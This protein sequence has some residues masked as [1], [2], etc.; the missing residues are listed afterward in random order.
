MVSGPA[1][2]EKVATQYTGIRAIP[3]YSGRAMKFPRCIRLDTS[4]VYVYRRA[5]EPGEWAV[6]GGFAFAGADPK[7]LDA[8]ER[9][10]FQSGWLGTESFGHSSLVEVAEIEEA[11]FFQVVE[12]LARHFV[13]AYGA[14]DITAALPA[15][16]QEV[17]DAA[18]LCTHK[19]HSL[20][21]LEREMTDA[22]VVERFRVITPARAQDHARIWESLPDLDNAR[23]TE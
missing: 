9:L 13:A 6:P 22:G 16:R 18:G 10:A 1:D 12:R 19:I 17:D 7:A 8:K 3:D 5:A 14:P 4:D 2:E 21:A 15:A 11:E 23:D 20:L